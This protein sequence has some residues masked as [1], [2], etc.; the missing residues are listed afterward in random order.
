MSGRQH[1][2]CPRRLG[3]QNLS[4]HRCSTLRTPRQVMCPRGGRYRNTRREITPA[5]PGQLRAN[6]GQSSASAGT[7]QP[8]IAHFHKPRWQDMG[9]KAL[10]KRHHWER[11]CSILAARA[12]TIAKGYM[13]IVRIEQPVVAERHP[14]HVGRQVF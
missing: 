12:M 6:V 13:S 3:C 9:Q 8:V 11:A 2:R 4:M 14:K 7:E 5:V 1:R 10:D